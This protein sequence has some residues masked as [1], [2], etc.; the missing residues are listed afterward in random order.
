[1]LDLKRSHDSATPFRVSPNIPV[2]EARALIE[3][4]KLIEEEGLEAVNRRH[5]LTTSAAIA[6]ITAL[7][8]EPWQRNK[9]SYSTL[10]TTVRIPQ[11]GNLNIEQPLGIVAPGDGELHHKLLRINHFGA[12]ANQQSVEE[13][14]LTLAELMHQDP[15]HALAA[16]RS[17][18]GNK[19]GK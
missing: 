4:L 6:G 19:V 14:I 17:I 5:R 16:Q 11:G 10:T 12:K 18:W 8:L 3:A 1:M 15:D 13:A 7:G 2:L 9:D